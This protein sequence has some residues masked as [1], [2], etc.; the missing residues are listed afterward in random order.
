MHSKR[1]EAHL[2]HQVTNGRTTH[3][4]KLEGPSQAGKKAQGKQGMVYGGKRKPHIPAFRHSEKRAP[5]PTLTP[6]HTNPAARWKPTS[7][8]PFRSAAANRGSQYDSQFGSLTPAMCF[9]SPCGSPC[10]AADVSPPERTDW[11]AKNWPALSLSPLRLD[12]SARH[13]QSSAVS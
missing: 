1:A 6:K 3:E 8:L 5:R 9:M 7:R 13:C 4:C 2:V 12:P 10:I 11:R